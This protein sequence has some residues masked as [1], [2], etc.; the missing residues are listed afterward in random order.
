MKI[1]T[2]VGRFIVLSFPNFSFSTG[3]YSQVVD[4]HY[5]IDTLLDFVILSAIIIQ[6]LYCTMIWWQER[7]VY[8]PWLLSLQHCDMLASL[9][10]L[11]YLVT[12]KESWKEKN[13]LICPGKYIALFFIFLLFII[14]N[15]LTKDIKLCTCL[16][17]WSHILSP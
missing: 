9:R 6:N 14:S 1:W 15:I 16:L 13:S 2:N 11:S 4:N 3:W 12:F 17:D 10:Y 8:W 5:T 7:L